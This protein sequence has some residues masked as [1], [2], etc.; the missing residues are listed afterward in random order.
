[1]CEIG[2]GLL[3]LVS[4]VSLVAFMMLREDFLGGLDPEARKRR[5]RRLNIITVVAWFVLVVAMGWGF[6]SVCPA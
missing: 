3:G 6:S 5:D 4:I 1:M 2:V